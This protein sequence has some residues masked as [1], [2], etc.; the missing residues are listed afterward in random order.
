MNKRK[1]LVIPVLLG[2]I[3]MCAMP[4]TSY[5][6]SDSSQ[7]MELKLE[8]PEQPETQIEASTDV[9]ILA[10]ISLPEG[11][12]WQDSQQKVIPG[13]YIS[14]VAVYKSG[15]TTK[16]QVGQACKIVQEKTDTTYVIGKDSKVVIYCTG[17]LS[18]LQGVQMDKKEVAESDYT[19]QEG[20]TILT[21]HKTY[22]DKLS[23]GKHMVTLNYEAG[24]VDSV[25]TVSKAGASAVTPVNPPDGGKVTG[26]GDFTFTASGTK[27][28]DT[29]NLS[30]MVIVM[31]LSAI[32]VLGLLR[33]KIK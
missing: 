26:T 3:C 11:W 19:T 5:A 4:I 33:R 14:A 21:F 28:G 24:S 12:T 18:K 10:E 6:A 29:T 30:G 32:T 25:F 23:E 15:V 9:K 16:I 22:L 31:F 1:R 17:T 27:T 7:S 2:M 20:S 13:G 8:V